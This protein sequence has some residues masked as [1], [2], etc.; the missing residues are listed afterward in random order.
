[1]TIKEKETAVKI[2]TGEKKMLL[3]QKNICLRFIMKDRYERFLKTK[4]LEYIGFKAN[5]WW[6]CADIINACNGRIHFLDDLLKEMDESMEEKELRSLYN[7]K[8]EIDE[9]IKFLQKF[10]QHWSNSDMVFQDTFVTNQKICDLL[11]IEK[12]KV[13]EPRYLMDKILP[14]L[15]KAYSDRD[16]IEEEIAEMMATDY[17]VNHSSI[18]EEY[19]EDVDSELISIIR[20]LHMDDG[21]DDFISKIRNIAREE[22]FITIL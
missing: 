1:M 10:Y 7:Q 17:A 21:Y 6:N 18:E 15:E 8:Q 9:N 14:F 13:Y 22:V 20:Q 5:R 16:K 11:G 2:F 19:D 4:K 12:R 3:E